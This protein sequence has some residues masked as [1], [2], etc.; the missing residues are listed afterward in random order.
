LKSTNFKKLFT[1]KRKQ[2]YHRDNI[3]LAEWISNLHSLKAKLSDEL[4]S[5]AILNTF[6]FGKP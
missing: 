4:K 5:V 1:F 6:E 3:G 2:V